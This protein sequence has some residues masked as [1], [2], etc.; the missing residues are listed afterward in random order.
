MRRGK[1]QERAEQAEQGAAAG[2]RETMEFGTLTADTTERE[3]L[4]SDS[5]PGTIELTEPDGDGDV[6]LP[7][8]TSHAECNARCCLDYKKAFQPTDKT[9]TLLDKRKRKFMPSWYEKF[10]WISVC[11]TNKKVFCACCRYGHNTALFQTFSKR[12]ETAFTTDGFC[13]WKKALEKF[14]KHERSD[15]H[16]LAMEK[17]VHVD[18]PNISE[19]CA[20]HL[21]SLQRQRRE[22]F[23]KQLK[24]SIETRSKHQR[25]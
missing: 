4:L 6:H 21:T 3:D 1:T 20:A 23:L 12:A 9:L 13:N 25:P 24:I 14:A 15:A 17:W 11:I 22:G 16:C 7:E 8:L 19:K 2:D 5:G 18:K 10:P